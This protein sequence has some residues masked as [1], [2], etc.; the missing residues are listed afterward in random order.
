MAKELKD[1]ETP[2]MA[3]LAEDSSPYFNG[4]DGAQSGNGNSRKFKKSWTTAKRFD[5]NIHS[6]S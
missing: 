5:E 1:A 6:M 2:A 4:R 3:N